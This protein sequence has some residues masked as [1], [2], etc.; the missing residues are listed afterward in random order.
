MQDFCFHCDGMRT[1]SA[2]RGPGRT[3]YH[4][5][6]CGHETDCDYDDDYADEWND[7]PTGSCDNCDT[8]LYADDDY[9]GLCGQCYWWLMQM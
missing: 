1:V 4:C 3:S 7:E 2:Q 8:N 6:T 5:A 9:G